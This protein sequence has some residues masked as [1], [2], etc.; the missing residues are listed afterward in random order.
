MPPMEIGSALVF[1]DICAWPIAI[2]A[3]GSHEVLAVVAPLVERLCMNAFPERH[4]TTATR[5][6]NRLAAASCQAGGANVKLLRG[7]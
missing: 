5:R 2:A 7:V 1:H 6:I 4:Q 3:I